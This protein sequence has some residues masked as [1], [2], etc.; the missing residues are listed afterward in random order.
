[1]SEHGE[2]AYMPGIAVES[3]REGALTS[4]DAELAELN[5][6]ISALV[7]D[8]A[9]ILRESEPEASAR[10]ETAPSSGLQARVHRLSEA[11]ER[12]LVLRRR[13]DL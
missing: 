1:V 12:L 10:L 7:D 11:R 6:V 3:K 9:E 5:G 13:I 4:L 2:R 8:L